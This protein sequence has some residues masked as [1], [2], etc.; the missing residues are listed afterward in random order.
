MRPAPEA[1]AV[2]AQRAGIPSD[3]KTRHAG[4]RGQRGED[5]RNFYSDKTT[6]VITR[7]TSPQVQL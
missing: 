7:H 3:T 2:L 1:V 4:P 6:A 5:Y